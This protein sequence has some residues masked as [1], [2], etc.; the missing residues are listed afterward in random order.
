MGARHSP[1]SNESA[2]LIDDVAFLSELENLKG[3]P[4]ARRVQARRG[5][6]P[7]EPVIPRD[8]NRWHLHPPPGV[9]PAPTVREGRSGGSAF[10]PIL[11]GFCAGAA[12]A[13]AVF[14]DRLTQVIAL[15]TR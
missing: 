8:V 13:A 12:G 1:Q 5:A 3:E 10:L 2:S 4:A 7:V 14:H 15:F 6:G 11:I 9:D